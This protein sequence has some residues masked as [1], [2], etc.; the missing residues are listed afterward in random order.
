MGDPRETWTFS[1]KRDR[2][3]WT[4]SSKRDRVN[5]MTDL[6]PDDVE[7]HKRSRILSYS[8]SPHLFSGARRTFVGHDVNA[9]TLDKKALG[10]VPQ[11][12]NTHSKR[13]LEQL[14]AKRRGKDRDRA[15]IWVGHSLGGLIVQNALVQASASVES[16][17]EH[18]AIELCTC[19]VLFFGTPMR[20]VP[21]RNWALLLSSIVSASMQTKEDPGLD[22]AALKSDVL[23]LEVQRYKSIAT[24]FQN[25]SFC[26]RPGFRVVPKESVTLFTHHWEKIEIDGN[27]RD[28]VKF[29][30]SKDLNYQKV[31]RRIKK[32]CNHA[33]AS[34]RSAEYFLK[35]DHI[36]QHNAVP[37]VNEPDLDGAAEVEELGARL[38]S[39]TSTEKLYEMLLTSERENGLVHRITIA[40]LEQL[41]KHY[42]A[43][44]RY[45]KA[46]LLYKRAFVAAEELNHG[47]CN[48]R[49][50]ALLQQLVEC[51]IKQ[52]KYAEATE[53]LWRIYSI[54]RCQF[55]D[56]GLETLKTRAN[57]AIMYDKQKLWLDAEKLYVQV[58]EARKKRIGISNEDTLRVMENLAL[59]YRL[60][61][62]KTWARSAAKYE[63]IIGYRENLLKRVR[64][65]SNQ[66]GHVPTTDEKDDGSQCSRIKDNVLKLAEVYEMMKNVQS[67]QRLFQHWSDLFPETRPGG[68]K[69]PQ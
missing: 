21:G 25:Y 10:Y 34:K 38:H 27:H 63:E 6:L 41:G 30:S 53:N 68:S 23:D 16:R 32:C 40:Y 26:E 42:M 44:A 49:V 56:E 59:N 31:L 9:K 61:S 47:P 14:S 54:Q 19:G 1:S 57:I 24:N 64:E 8:Y 11:A 55:G 65:S 43:N 45:L 7:S 62:K 69:R 60:R 66:Q 35:L 5:W 20:E 3:T 17:R 33:G 58:I 37:R 48:S 52:A 67:R 39:I 46:E 18:K 51:V 36:S 12:I 22:L 29:P 13:L 15:I 28:M 50:A 2:E 4:F